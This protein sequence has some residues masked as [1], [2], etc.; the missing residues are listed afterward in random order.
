MVQRIIHGG[1]CQGAFCDFACVGLQP[2]L[3]CVQSGHTQFLTNAVT[4]VHTQFFDLAF[5]GVEFVDVT[6]SHI[7]FGDVRGF[8]FALRLGRFGGLHEFAS[9]VIPTADPGDAVFRHTL[10]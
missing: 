5:D 10:P 1:K 3:Q 6:Q 4:L 9:G 7:G 2:G 8:A